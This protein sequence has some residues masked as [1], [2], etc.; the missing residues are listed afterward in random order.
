[1]PMKPRGRAFA[2]GGGPDR[3]PRIRTGPR[4][5]DSTRALKRDRK[6]LPPKTLAV[7]IQRM[8]GHGRELALFH[9][10]VVRGQRKNEAVSNGEI[11]KL[12]ATVTEKQR[13]V[14]W[15]RQAGWGKLPPTFEE[16]PD[17]DEADDGRSVTPEEA[18][19]RREEAER[20]H[21]SAVPSPTP[22]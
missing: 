2:K 7:I 10:E 5:E 12:E 14:E 20:R 15:L 19:R 9:L 11:L 1:M 6:P 8:T 4:S 13:S 22:R 3:D 17:D 18:E 21:L 16:M